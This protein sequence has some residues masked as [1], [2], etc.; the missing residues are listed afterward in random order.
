MLR[1]E[2]RVTRILAIVGVAALALIA[3]GFYA[4]HG[5]GNV[6]WVDR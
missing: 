1:A 3:F 6:K 5:L 2:R 4:L